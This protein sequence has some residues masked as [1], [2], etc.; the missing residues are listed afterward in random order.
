[1]TPRHKGYMV[2]ERRIGYEKTEDICKIGMAWLVMSVSA[3]LLSGCAALPLAPGGEAFGEKT[4]SAQEND[5]RDG[6]CVSG[7]ADA[8]KKWSDIVFWV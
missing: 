5:R 1:M 7:K 8:A 2:R 4:Y 3:V 6:F